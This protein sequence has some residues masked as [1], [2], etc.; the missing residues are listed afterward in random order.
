MADL[1]S[2]TPEPPDGITEN[3]SENPPARK[4]GR[5][6]IFEAT[7]YGPRRGHS[8]IYTERS[9]L[10]DVY[11]VNALLTLTDDHPDR[12]RYYWL[13]PDGSVS[14]A[15]PT[16][17]LARIRPKVKTVLL[18]ELG[19]ILAD[20]GEETMRRVAL[21]LCEDKPKTQDAVRWLRAQRLQRE[22]RAGTWEALCEHLS[23]ALDDYLARYPATPDAVVS[24][25]LWTQADEWDDL[26]EWVAT[27][28]TKEQEAP[29]PEPTP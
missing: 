27:E 13:C 26:V 21:Q 23:R 14:Y 11:F 22:P 1:T 7:A 19:R 24:S 15:Y 20:Y 10:N 8:R 16:L 4:R 9:R 18:T 6:R 12:D 5:P 17:P 28:K 25:A 29:S 2:S 3:F